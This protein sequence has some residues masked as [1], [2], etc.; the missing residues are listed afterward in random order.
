MTPRAR[1]IVDAGISKKRFVG[2]FKPHLPPRSGPGIQPGTSVPG[3]R[4]PS[5]VP[6]GPKARRQYY[7]SS[8]GPILPMPPSSSCRVPCR[9]A[10]T[11][12]SRALSTYGKRAPT[13]NSS[14]SL[15]ERVGVRVLGFVAQESSLR[16]HR[17]WTIEHDSREAATVTA[18]PESQNH[19]GWPLNDS[20]S[21]A[22]IGSCHDPATF[23]WAHTR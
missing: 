9:G 19:R 23:S 3:S 4:T 2:H 8:F 20:F 15:W 1:S 17:R 18:P 16:D 12:F 21:D 7:E 11:E 6:K 14:L 10:A 13:K 5:P 22:R